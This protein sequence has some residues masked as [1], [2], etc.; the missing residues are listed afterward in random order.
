MCRQHKKKTGNVNILQLFVVF[1]FT[2][3]IYALCSN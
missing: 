2:D 3:C 1:L